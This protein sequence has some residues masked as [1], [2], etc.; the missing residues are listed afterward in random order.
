ML[1]PNW[2][3][4]VVMAQSALQVIK[5]IHQPSMLGVLARSSV[6]QATERMSE[7]DWR[8][9]MPVES[10][11]IG[12]FK[13][14]KLAQSTRLQGFDICY[15][16]QRM[17]KTALFLLLSGIKKRIGHFENRLQQSKLSGHTFTKKRPKL[18]I[19]FLKESTLTNK[20]QTKPK[21]KPKGLT[22]QQLFLDLVGG[23]FVTQ[24][25]A[26]LPK[27]NTDETNQQHLIAKF[28]LTQPLVALCPAATHGK[29]PAKMWPASCFNELALSLIKKGFNVVALG[30][31]G[32]S[33][34]ISFEPTLQ[35]NPAFINLM[36]KT[37][38]TDAVDILGLAQ[39]CVANDSGLM[40]CANAVGCAVVAIYGATSPHFSPP[41]SHTKTITMNGS[42]D[43]WPCFDR[44]C[45]FGHYQCLKDTS[46]KQVHQAVI[47]LYEALPSLTK[48][49]QNPQNPQINA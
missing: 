16:F 43:C 17:E 26:F 12:F 19:D 40:H 4:D 32:D 38:L 11:E 44:S 46:V 7:V 9:V 10:G 33:S 5:Q 25:N 31:K 36:G 29:Q 35:S 1:L 39:V 14:I 22:Q 24:S 49:P 2:L 3:G 8:G 41:L 18:S 28:K 13:Q 45:R 6:L 23:E 21:S 30:S 37:S 47:R 20:G 48:N 15:N 42:V 34:H 27:L